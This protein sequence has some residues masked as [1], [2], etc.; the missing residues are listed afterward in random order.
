MEKRVW[1]FVLCNL[2]KN[3]IQDSKEMAKF[4]GDTF[5]DY[6]SNSNYRSEF[7]IFRS[8]IENTVYQKININR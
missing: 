1:D 6:F 3:S 4:T 7:T 2:G 8:R 5:E